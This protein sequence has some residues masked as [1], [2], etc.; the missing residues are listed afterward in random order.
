[1]GEGYHD[2][3]EENESG[4]EVM[5]HIPNND[6]SEED[7]EIEE[8]DLERK[9][10]S[11]S[12]NHVS[13]L[14]GS[15]FQLEEKVPQQVPPTIPDEH[16]DLNMTDGQVIAA[17]STKATFD[18]VVR[19][20]GQK[21]QDE[22]HARYSSYGIM[23]G[24][25]KYDEDL[26]KLMNDEQMHSEIFQKETFCGLK[27]LLTDVDTR[28]RP[29]LL[30]IQNI[31][32]FSPIVLNDLIH[33]LKLY[34]GAPHF[35]NFNL[36]LGVQSNN[37]EEIHLR[38]SIQNCTKLVVKTFHFPSMKNIIFEVVY[39]MLSSRNTLLTFEPAVIQTLIQ[40]INLFGMSVMK[41]KRILKV[42]IAEH[43]YK[44][45]D[46]FFVHNV[47]MTLCSK[48]EFAKIEANLSACANSGFAEFHKDCNQDQRAEQCAKIVSATKEYVLKR[49]HW[50]KAFEVISELAC[51][52]YQT[53]ERDRRRK[54]LM[55]KI[56]RG[57][58]L[59]KN[60]KNKKTEAQA[61]RRKREREVN[62]EIELF[63][64]PSK[65]LG[66]FRYQFILNY[67]A[68]PSTTEKVKF[69]MNI[70]GLNPNW[71][72]TVFKEL[73][74]TLQLRKTKLKVETQKG[75]QV[76]VERQST[77]IK[78]EV[79][80]VESMLKGEHQFKKHQRE[81]DRR[82]GAK[83]GAGS[84]QVNMK[85][86]AARQ[87]ALL[88]GGSKHRRAQ[89]QEMAENSL[90][91]ANIG[92]GEIDDAKFLEACKNLRPKDDHDYRQMFWSWME[93][94][95]GRYLNC[96]MSKSS[97]L[98]RTLFHVQKNDF[99]D[100][101]N[102]DISGNMT[103]TIID[104]DWIFEETQKLMDQAAEAQA[105]AKQ[106]GRPVP[107]PES[108]EITPIYRNDDTR[109]GLIT[110]ED[111]ECQE[112]NTKILYELLKFYGRDANIYDMYGLF[113]TIMKKSPNPK[114]LLKG[115]DY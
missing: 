34:R 15:S 4:D 73:L 104:S 77:F 22:K 108:R 107:P 64:V 65:E 94:F 25:D 51:L 42:L 84:K 11:M 90:A 59:D 70:Y 106:E 115:E 54:V 41:F 47:H 28:K 26:S 6:S 49:R 39:K 80:V 111:L 92:F 46:Y 52:A 91:Q 61:T 8:G 37:K 23:G 45:Q 30:I 76:Q 38:V 58:Q 9:K 21:I 12:T 83:I 31:K 57:E 86:N 75:H 95:H 114:K 72:D 105:K 79:D 18:G 74:P 48:K 67:M 5:L 88:G 55:D 13:T 50:F 35:I 99:D 87:E 10:V 1:M 101:I 63:E 36:M 17:A 71:K 96:E 44:N 102:P 89:Q 112:E 33:H 68:Q 7:G 14:R 100:K 113:K 98:Q 3:V 32:S 19:T 43:I 60:D 81:G 29:V 40:T 78:T 109:K 110:V 103:K 66:I 82:F 24:R 93:E 16:V 20:R 53:I 27:H 62:E 85:S 2:K 69:I 56:Q 97:A